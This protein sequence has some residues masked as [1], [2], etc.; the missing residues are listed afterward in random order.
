MDCSSLTE[1]M[2]CRAAAASPATEIMFSSNDTPAEEFDLAAQAGRHHQPG[3]HHPHRLSG[4][5]PSASIPETICC[6]YNPGGDVRTSATTSHG[7][8]RRRQVRHDPRADVRG[9]PQAEG[10]WARSTSA[11]TPSWPPT[12]S[13]NDYYPDAG[14]ACSSSWRWSCTRRPA[15]TSPSSTSPAAWASPTARSSRQR[16][17]PPSA[18]AC[19]RLTRRSWCPR[20]WATWR[21]FTELG[22]FML[23]PYGCLVTTAIHEKHIYKEYIGVDACAGQPHAPGHV[24]RLPP[25]HR[26]WAR[27]TRPATTCTT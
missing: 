7:Q 11:S 3:R 4:A 8:P 22:R 21:I 10:A 5:R 14:R 12:P 26:R 6:R 23:A 13:T 27:R 2:L 18:R 20:A 24:R 1:L 9:L 15:R 16:T 17:S 25:H 19:A